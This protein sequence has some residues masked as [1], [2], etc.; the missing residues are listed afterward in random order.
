MYQPRPCCKESSSSYQPIS[1]KKRNLL[2]SRDTHSLTLAKKKRK[3]KKEKEEENTSSLQCCHKINP[4]RSR[5][6]RET[7][8]VFSAF[9]RGNRN[10]ATREERERGE[11]CVAGVALENTGST[12]RG[13]QRCL[14]AS[15]LSRRSARRDEEKGDERQRDIIYVYT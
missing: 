14:S 4:S 9:A 12:A 7:Y 2:T 3:Q 13:W 11:G 15:C 1:L 6:G 10:N 8:E 5:E